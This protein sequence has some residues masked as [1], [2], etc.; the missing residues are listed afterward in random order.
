MFILKKQKWF[1]WNHKLVVRRNGILLQK[2]SFR[3]GVMKKIIILISAII[4][5]VN[6]FSQAVDWLWARAAGGSNNDYGNSVATD[7]SGHVYM[8]GFFESASITFGTT[9][10]FNAGPTGTP[11]MFLAKYDSLGN[12][13]WAKSAGGNYY[14]KSYS[15]AVDGN[16]NI[17][18]T[19]YFYSATIV[20]GTV[21]LNNPGAGYADM[22]IVKYNSGGTVL[23]AKSAGGIDS[24]ISYC[25]ATDGNGNVYATGYF[26]SPSIT[27]GTI[28]L[29]N[30]GYPA[31]EI[32]IVKYNASG[33]VLWAK[34][35]GGVYADAGSGVAVDG[36]GNV[37]LTGNFTSSTVTF[38][39]TTLTS[40]GGSNIFITKYDSTGTVRWARTSEGSS[41]DYGNAV[42]TD[43]NGNV[44]VTGYY[45]YFPI[46]FGTDTLDNAGQSDLFVVK[47]DSVGSVLWSRSAG[48]SND[49]IGISVATDGSGNIYLTGHFFSSSITFGTTSLINDGNNDIFVVKYNSAGNAFWAKRAGGVAPESGQGV[50]IDAY[51][52]VYVTGIFNSTSLSFG[53]TVLNNSGAGSS[54]IFLARID[55]FDVGIEEPGYD[56]AVCIFPNP[57]TNE[58]KVQS[59]T[60]KVQRVEIYDVM[61]QKCLTPTLS[62]GE[63]VSASINVSELIAGIYFVKVK[64]GKRE[65]V[66]KLVKQ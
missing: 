39:T 16:G 51:D 4:F 33:T 22:F 25:V 66:F 13:L 6:V 50:A 8:T 38:G 24:D 61:G 36:S 1:Q 44:Y 56:R 45:S 60:F 46:I 37:F 43:G 20:F 58:I 29:N 55:S 10:L 2:Q 31:S 28:T 41:A 64:A 40:S 14:D 65:Q 62:K 54:D 32:F 63:G 49:D 9:T 30:P 12:V 5:S 59:S 26:I 57:A 47:Y 48:G 21:T 42:A 35:T 7:G 34:S 11:D 23:W 18:V 53:T 19:G 17:F 15:V 27:F 3:S 52:N